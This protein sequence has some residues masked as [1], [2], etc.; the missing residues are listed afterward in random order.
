LKTVSQSLDFWF[1]KVT[2]QLVFMN[3]CSELMVEQ[4]WKSVVLSNVQ[5]YSRC[6]NGMS[7]SSWQAAEWWSLHC[8]IVWRLMKWHVITITKK[9]MNYIPPYTLIKVV[10]W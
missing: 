9:R 5:V 10:L 4:L 8:R 6:F 3:I 2:Y 7:R 1:L